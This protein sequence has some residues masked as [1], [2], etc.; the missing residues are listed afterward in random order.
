MA[1][2]THIQIGT[3][4]P[5]G[6]G[7]VNLVNSTRNAIELINQYAGILNA[8][9]DDT[10]GK[11]ALAAALSLTDV[12]AAVAVRTHITNVQTQITHP[13]FVQLLDDLGQ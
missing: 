5:V 9:G 1:A 13:Y 3:T 10:A 12:D 2:G 4:Q 11:A 8:F 6:A 7:V